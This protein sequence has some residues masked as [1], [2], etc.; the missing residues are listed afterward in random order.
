MSDVSPYE[1]LT[2]EEMV[3]LT[4]SSLPRAEESAEEWKNRAALE[5]AQAQAKA[6]QRREEA[7]HTP[8]E[9]PSSEEETHTED[10]QA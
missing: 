8:V 4:T 10:P 6:A 1:G 7:T 9:L 5:A 3:E 2:E